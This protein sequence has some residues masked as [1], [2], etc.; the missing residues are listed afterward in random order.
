M[1]V[2][3]VTLNPAIDQTVS[4]NHFSMNTV[5]R[6]LGFQ[7]DAGGKGVNVASFLADYGA[8]VAATGFLGD[9]NPEIFEQLFRRKHIADYF[10]RLNGLTRIGIKIAD[11]AKQQTTDINLPGLAPSAGEL[12]TLELTIDQLAA[13]YDWFVLA[14]NLPP[15]VPTTWY[16]SVIKRLNDQGKHV[17]LD[18]SRD[19]LRAGVAAAPSLIKPN[20]D[21]LS[22]VVGKPLHDL[23]EVERAAHELLKQG[24]KLVVVSMG[25]RGALFVNADQALVAIPPRVD[26][27]STVGAGDAMVAGTV[28]GLIEERP[29]AEIAKL[30]TAFSC[31]TLTIIGAHLAQSPTLADLMEQVEIRIQQNHAS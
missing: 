17:I 16:P 24:I 18:T 4:V 1:K 31:S 8:E 10:V 15:H 26:V 9:Q 22:D 30:A 5:N 7:L 25:E 14:G 6:G 27:K 3:T 28:A 12:E 11:Q 29:L 2:A 19:A 23:N 13:D 21:E 20:I